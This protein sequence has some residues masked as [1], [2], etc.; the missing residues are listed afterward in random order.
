MI[1]CWDIRKNM[2]EAFVVLFFNG[3]SRT[4]W[5]I[6]VLVLNSE[7]SSLATR[8]IDLV[9]LL[10]SKDYIYIYKCYLPLIVTVFLRTVDNEI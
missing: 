3:Q 10:K 4:G 2:Y 9:I 7:Q 8:F 1:S 5:S 6:W